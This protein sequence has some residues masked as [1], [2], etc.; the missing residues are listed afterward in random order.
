MLSFDLAHYNLHKLEE[1]FSGLCLTFSQALLTS[2]HPDLEKVVLFI[3]ERKLYQ[4][5][6][7]IVIGI[8]GR[9][10]SKHLDN[11][12]VDVVRYTGVRKIGFMC[13]IY[14]V[15]TRDGHKD[16]MRRLFP[17]LHENGMMEFYQPE[18]Q[19]IW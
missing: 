10:L 5:L 14:S 3:D 15:L 17:M 18:D 12:L 13:S 2:I 19:Y 4:P 11:T 1:R 16:C 8:D 9:V 6:G 7:N